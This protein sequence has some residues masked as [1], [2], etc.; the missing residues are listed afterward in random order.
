MKSESIKHLGAAD[1][2]EAFGGRGETISPKFARK[3]SE[4]NFKL[5]RPTEQNRDEILLEVL[6]RIQ[7]D[8]QK[9][10]SK[11]REGEWQRGWN[12]NLEAYRQSK[13]P[14]SLTPLFMRKGL[15]IR[16]QGKFYF[17]E[18]P[19][20]EVNFNE[21]LRAYVFSIFKD[22]EIF[23]IHEFGAGTGWNL[24]QAWDFF[25]RDSSL[26]LR[27]SDFVD[28]SVQLMQELAKNSGAPI[29][30]TRFDMRKPDR[31]YKLA[32]PDHAAVLTSGSLEQLGG[33][34][35]PMLD[36]LVNLRPSLIVS[37]EPAE[38]TYD[39]DS[40][41]DFTAHWFQSKRG[42][43]SGL[44]SALRR[45]E[46]AGVV[47]IERIKRIGFGSMMMEGYNLFVWRVV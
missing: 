24:L 20:F 1:F 13:D 19:N 42:Y 36:F 12:E 39:L 21:V 46:E 10:A 7:T 34:I 43:S 47:A 17:S 32:E 35:E 23:E 33:D 27:G 2:L 15:P 18:D 8:T 40:L 9:I 45:R 41:E 30:A 4:H 26:I 29:E 22:R 3:V 11:N 37:I 38:E 25:D 16:W 31:N 14:K 6:K 28:S 44:I 5:L